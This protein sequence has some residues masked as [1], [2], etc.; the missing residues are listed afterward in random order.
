M[1]FR[2]VKFVDGADLPGSQQLAYPGRNDEL[3]LST[4]RQP[5]QGGQI[6]MIVVIVAEEYGID[7]G[8]I[9]PPHARLPAAARTDRGERTCA[10]GPDRIGQNVEVALLE[11]HRGMVDQRNPQLSAFNARRRLGLLHVRNETGGW[12]RPAGELPS[13]NIEKAARRG[14]VGIEE[15]LPVK[16]PRKWQCAAGML[17]RF[18]FTHSF[19]AGQTLAQKP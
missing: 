19:R 7:P 13:Q 12:L 2:S 18:L 17:H 9:L 15:A 3:S 5:A 8:K 6:Q 11:Q 16:V 14:G 4:V 10:V 1:L